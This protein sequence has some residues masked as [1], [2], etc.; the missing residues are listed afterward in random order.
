M[1]DA[2]FEK[3]LARSALFWM[4]PL[5]EVTFVCLTA[6]VMESN[7]NIEP[8]QRLSDIAIAAAE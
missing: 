8:F 2:M 6:G 7:D 3:G 4:V 5:R 1:S